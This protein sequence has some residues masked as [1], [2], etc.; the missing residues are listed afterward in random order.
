MPTYEY[1]CSVEDGG[2]GHKFEV[3]QNMKDKPLEECP[4]CKKS[5]LRKLFGVPAV[6]FKGTGFYETD[7]KE[8][9]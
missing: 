5:K 6:I 1:E 7:Y 9:K 4:N 2:C 8:K 3:F